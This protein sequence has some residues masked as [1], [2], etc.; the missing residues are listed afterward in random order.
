MPDYLIAALT[1]ATGYMEY[2][3]TT[4]RDTY[5]PI[6]HVVKDRDEYLFRM[7]DRDEAEQLVN[8]L[9]E[10]A[11]LRDATRWRSVGEELP[12]P[13]NV[14]LAWCNYL[15]PTDAPFK[16]FYDLGKWWTDE[17]DPVGV[18]YWQPL[19]APPEEK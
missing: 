4:V 14:V 19:P 11:R 6:C 17:G 16:A 9:N 2:S 3:C 18:D 8:M 7:I 12:H 5:G 15:T 10:L 1:G 13:T